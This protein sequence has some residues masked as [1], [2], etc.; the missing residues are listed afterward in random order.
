MINEAV[1]KQ[2]NKPKIYYPQSR[3]EYPQDIVYQPQPHPQQPQQQQV[4][5]P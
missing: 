2:I 4:E 1:N 3:L 5:I